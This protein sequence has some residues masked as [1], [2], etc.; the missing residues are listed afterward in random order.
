MTK[1]CVQRSLDSF[2]TTNKPKID[3]AMQCM[4]PLSLWQERCWNYIIK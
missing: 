4:H 2:I 3:L 1:L